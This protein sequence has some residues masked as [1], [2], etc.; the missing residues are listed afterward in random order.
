MKEKVMVIAMIG[1]AFYLGIVVG[2]KKYEAEAV[3]K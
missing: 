2:K 3:I 1:L